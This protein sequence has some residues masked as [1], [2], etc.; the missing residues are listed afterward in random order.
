V[1]GEVTV[2]A[3]NDLLRSQLK[4]G[5]TARA[6]WQAAQVLACVHGRLPSFE[7][8]G[9]RHVGL[10]GSALLPSKHDAELPLRQWVLT[11]PY[12]WCKRLGY[13]AA[14]L[15]ALTGIFIKTVLGFYRQKSG[16]AQAGGKS[17]AVVCVQRTSSDLKLN[18]HLPRFVIPEGVHAVFLDGAYLEDVGASSPPAAEADAAAPRFLGLGHRQTREVSEVLE[19]AIARMLRYCKRRKLLAHD[20]D[21]AEADQAD[22]ESEEMRGHA[23]LIAS[24]VSGVN[25]PAG[26]SFPHR[27]AGLVAHP[28]ARAGVRST[29]FERPLCVG[30]DG[31]TLHAATRAGGADLEGRE[32][33]L[34]YDPGK[35]PTGDILRPAVA[36]ERILRGKEGLVRITLKRAFSDGTVAVDMDPLSLL[37]RLAAAVPYPRF[38]PF[39]DHEARHTVRYSGVLASA[40][41]MRKKIAPKQASVGAEDVQACVHGALEREVQ[42]RG[43]P[44]RA[45]RGR[46]S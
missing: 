41:K 43:P 4:K 24:A 18:P 28:L 7:Q 31:F 11:F 20:S 22:V 27:N 30:R 46:S 19:R 38:S 10:S 21:E 5:A 40:S 9:S 1:L 23:E 2:K 42:K 37:C 15:S 35:S 3:P 36:Q 32:A 45:R 29:D 8:Q 13:N 17:G 26:P 44:P 25:P 14:L 12:A 34:K 16:G 39:G 6:R 33:L